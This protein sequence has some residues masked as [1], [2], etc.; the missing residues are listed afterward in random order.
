M[1]PVM[2][3]FGY[4]CPAILREL[5]RGFSLNN[6]ALGAAQLKKNYPFTCVNSIFSLFQ[7]VDVPRSIS[8][9]FI[10]CLFAMQ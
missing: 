4:F 10:E 5:Y 6:T 3:E 1:H 2:P 7:T 8:P 9:V